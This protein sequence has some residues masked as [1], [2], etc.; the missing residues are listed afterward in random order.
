[1]SSITACLIPMG[2]WCDS[3]RN[4]LE[5]TDAIAHWQTAWQAMKRISL[6]CSGDENAIT[7]AIQR[8]INL[9]LDSGRL[10]GVA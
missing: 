5:K 7:T 4:Q 3:V 2:V 8:W 10:M 1:M 6:D 9:Y